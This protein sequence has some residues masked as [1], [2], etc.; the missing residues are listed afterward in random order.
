MLLHSL[1]RLHAGLIRTCQDF[2]VASGEG[3]PLSLRKAIRTDENRFACKRRLNM[4]KKSIALTLAAFASIAV[5]IPAEA[6]VNQRQDRQ[7]QRINQG[8]TNGSL[9]DR[10]IAALQKQQASI[11]AFEARSRADGPG[12]TKLE[13]AR[14]EKRQDKASRNIRRQRH[15]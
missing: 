14:I 7:Q 4:S 5:A 10:E 9:S 12:L 2:S 8:I 15:D 13:R 11:A 1:L 3:F 6:R